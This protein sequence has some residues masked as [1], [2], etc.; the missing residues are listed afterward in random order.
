MKVELAKA[1]AMDKFIPTLLRNISDKSSHS[2]TGTKIS[3]RRPSIVVLSKPLMNR[4]EDVEG[5]ESIDH[6]VISLYKCQ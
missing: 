1:E 5:R 2:G 6:E 3:S 4:I